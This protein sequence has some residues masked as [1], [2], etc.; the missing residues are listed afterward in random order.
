VFTGAW[1][2]GADVKLTFIIRFLYALFFS[3]FLLPSLA[4]TRPSAYVFIRCAVQTDRRE[5]R[6]C[7]DR[8]SSTE[9]A[10]RTHHAYTGIFSWLFFRIISRPSD[11]LYQNR[12]ARALVH[13][14]ILRERFSSRSSFCTRSGFIRLRGTRSL[15]DSNRSNPVKP[16]LMDT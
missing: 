2:A 6:G 7:F 12:N 16:L 13:E 14:S 15:L 5:W 8:K 1:R 3:F 4:R 11:A 10:A 9:Y